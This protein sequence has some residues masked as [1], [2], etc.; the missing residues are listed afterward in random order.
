[1]SYVD[2]V[3]YNAILFIYLSFNPIN[4]TSQNPRVIPRT[5]GAYCIFLGAFVSYKKSQF[6]KMFNNNTNVS[7]IYFVVDALYLKGLVE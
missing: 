3:L 1:M 2:D 7:D 5:F 6:S 4:I